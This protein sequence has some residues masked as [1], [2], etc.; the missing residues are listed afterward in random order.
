M[1]AKYDKILG[2]LREDDS[3]AG[4]GGGISFQETFGLA[5]TDYASGTASIGTQYSQAFI[6]QSDIDV[7]EIAY[8]VTNA[9]ASKTVYCGLYNSSGT[10]LDDGSGNADATGLNTAT[11]DSTVSLTAGTLY[12]IGLLCGDGAPNFLADS[13]MFGDN[14]RIARSGFVSVTP[15]GTA[16]SIS[17]HTNTTTAFWLA[18]KA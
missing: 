13:T 6:P 18:V 14:A 7:T 15:T 8:W 17:A 12:Y 3:A 10:L 11:L 9:S 1:A 2:K 4:A 5:A 16:A